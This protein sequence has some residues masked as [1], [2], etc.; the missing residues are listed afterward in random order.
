[1]KIQELFEQTDFELANQEP[2]AE[3]VDAIKDFIDTIDPQS[4]TP[5][6]V[7]TRLQQLQQEYP[8]LDRITDMIPQTR[9]VKQ[10]ALAVDSLVAN[11]PV[12]ALAHLGQVVGGH[13]ATAATVAQ[14]AQSLAKGDIKGAAQQAFGATQ[15]GRDYNRGQQLAQRVG[16]AAQALNDPKQAYTDIRNRIIPQQ[17]PA[18]VVDKTNELERLKQLSGQS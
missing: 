9:M 5:Q 2:S 4:D 13:V 15:I 12:D 7:L 3:D 8:L 18:P 1:M 16:Q 17:A 14:T 6:Q 11:R 10:I